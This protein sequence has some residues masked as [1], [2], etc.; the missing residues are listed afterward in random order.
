M[1]HRL[2]RWATCIAFLLWLPLSL[3]EKGPGG[4][5]REWQRGYSR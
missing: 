3:W 1:N 4:E 2:W 5:V